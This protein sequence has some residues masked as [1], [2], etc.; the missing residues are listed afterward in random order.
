MDSMKRECTVSILCAAYNHE[1]YIRSALDGFL[2]QR[3]DFAFEILVNDDCSSDNTAAI[4]REYAERYPKLIR[5]FYQPVN[6]YSLKKNVYDEVFIPKA[7]GKYLALCEGDDYWTDP[8]KLRLQVEFMEAHPEYSACVHNTV[9]HVCHSEQPDEL[10]IPSPGDHPVPFELAVRGMS[11]A[12]HTSSLLARKDIMARHPDFY[13]ISY[14]YGVGD[15]PDALW[16]ALNGPIWFIDRPMS[17]YRICSNPNSWS[18]DLDRDYN[19]RTHFVIGEI[20][21][22]TALRAHV[23]GGQL[24]AVDREL[25]LRQ[26]ELME[27]KG[28]SAQQLRPPYDEIYRS[29]DFKYRLKHF[30]KRSFPALH[31]LY[32]RKKGY[33]DW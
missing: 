25:H 31:S 13:Y 17:V 19:K 16:L 28:Q 32:R 15:Y 5:P 8:D 11:H 1:P 9:K 12:Y 24:E 27:L 18:A 20:D 6:L 14:S 10:L 33:G 26:Y 3:T 7:R 4:I 30:L 2:S 22:L 29:K 23:S 21:M